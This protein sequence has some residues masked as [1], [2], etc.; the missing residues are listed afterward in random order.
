MQS[1]VWA[2][3]P[4]SSS[5]TPPFSLSIVTNC[6]LRPFLQKFSFVPLPLVWPLIASIDTGQNAPLP[7]FQGRGSPINIARP[8]GGYNPTGPP[9]G[10]QKHAAAVQSTVWAAAVQ[11]TVRAYSHPAGI[12]ESVLYL[13]LARLARRTHSEQRGWLAQSAGLPSVS[14]RACSRA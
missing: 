13:Y 10:S 2:W 7:K 14:S 11:S 3:N 4:T 12:S 6:W 8:S 1:P 9:L 5:G